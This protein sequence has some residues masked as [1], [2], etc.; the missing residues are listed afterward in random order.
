[1][2]DEQL[3][4]VQHVLKGCVVHWSIP[5]DVF[6]ILDV[7]VGSVVKKSLNHGSVLGVNSEVQRCLA[8]DVSGILVNFAFLKQSHSVMDVVMRNA[9]EQNVVSDFLYFC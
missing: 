4:H 5:A 7:A 6:M 9:M 1:M 3:N 8:V 2:L